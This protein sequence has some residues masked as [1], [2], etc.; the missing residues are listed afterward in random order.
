VTVRIDGG[1]PSNSRRIAVDLP[2]NTSGLKISGVSDGTTWELNSLDLRKGNVLALWVN[3]LPENADRANLR[4]LLGGQRLPVVFVS[5]EQVNAEVPHGI[6]SGRFEVEIEIIGGARSE[7][8]AI[9][10]SGVVDEVKGE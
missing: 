4:V 10:V 2:P 5:A 7:P 6:L 8:I 3:G 1:P 9:E